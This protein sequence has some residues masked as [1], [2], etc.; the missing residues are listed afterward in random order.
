MPVADVQIQNY[1]YPYSFV[2]ETEVSESVSGSIQFID[3]QDFYNIFKEKEKGRSFADY[4]VITQ[5]WIDESK[6]F[7]IIYPINNYS[8]LKGK[9]DR[10]YK[11]HTD[12][13]K[14]NNSL[15]YDIS[16]YLIKNIAKLSYEKALVELSPLNEI[17]FKLVLNENTLLILSKPFDFLDGSNYETIIYSVFIN[18]E[19]LL[20]D[21]VNIKNLE[22]AIN[23]YL[24]PEKFGEV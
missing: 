13:I 24:K 6:I 7:D 14:I 1:R 10:E 3:A 2:K 4:E 5:N 20:N 22:E 12:Y 21:Y 17:K 8:D 11:N 23:K 16:D 18:K 9:I 19:L 15:F